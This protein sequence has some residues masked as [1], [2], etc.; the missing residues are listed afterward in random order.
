M[1]KFEIL[2]QEANAKTAVISHGDADGIVS[3]AIISRKLIKQR[4]PHI[5]MI[6]MDPTSEMTQEMIEQSMAIMSRDNDI[7]ECDIYIADRDIHS[8]E[9][10]FPIKISNLIW[11]DHHKTNIEKFMEK[12]DKGN[13]KYFL[14]LDS[15]ESGATMAYRAIKEEM[16]AEEFYGVEDWAKITALWDTFTWKKGPKEETGVT[17]LDIEKA[18]ILSKASYTLPA[19]Y[20]YNLVVLT[21]MNR[22]MQTLKI[23]ADIYQFKLNK[24]IKDAEA[25]SFRFNLYKESKEK[26]GGLVT[27]DISPE[28]ISLFADAMFNAHPDV[29]YVVTL[30]NGLVSTRVR[31]SCDLDTSAVMKALGTKFGFSGGGHQ[32]AAGCKYK[33]VLQPQAP[34]T[35]MN[36]LFTVMGSI[37]EIIKD[38]T[39]YECYGMDWS[40]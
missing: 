3:A 33:D 21:P 31:Q 35:P 24:A 36:D 39:G 38:S 25:K 19:G 7:Q 2:L 30:G 28:F 18:E 26:I 13:V 8:L 34:I 27:T 9:Y 20:L 23:A 29:D 15:T 5:V 17:A 1:N 37:V 40:K 12:E 32:K 11:C 14:T 10:N 16:P 6:S 22:C 4:I